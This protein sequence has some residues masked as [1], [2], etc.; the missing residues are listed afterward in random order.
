[1]PWTEWLPSGLNDGMVAGS[2]FIVVLTNRPTAFAVSSEAIQAQRVF[3]PKVVQS[4]SDGVNLEGTTVPSAAG[5][6][7]GGRTVVFSEAA[8]EK[9]VEQAQSVAGK[10]KSQWMKFVPQQ[11][12]IE[13]I[14]GTDGQGAHFPGLLAFNAFTAVFLNAELKLGPLSAREAIGLVLSSMRE[15][16]HV[17]LRLKQRYS[18]LGH[19]STGA[20]VARY[21]LIMKSIVCIAQRRCRFTATAPTAL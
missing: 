12:S 6:A 21:S 2:P 9:Y 15:K 8:F 1:M 4:S 20:F 3:V 11:H 18:W 10:I 5:V 13:P 14:C 16:D 17:E 19:H 7:G